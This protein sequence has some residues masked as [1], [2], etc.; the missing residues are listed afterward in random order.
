MRQYVP[1]SRIRMFHA[2]PTSATPTILP[3][4]LSRT[5]LSLLP[6][7]LLHML[8]LI[9]PAVVSDEGLLEKEIALITRESLKVRKVEELCVEMTF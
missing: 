5:S 6:R 9:L 7:A 4:P 8:V 3:L 1:Y 2:L